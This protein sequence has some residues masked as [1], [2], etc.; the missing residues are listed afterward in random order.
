MHG[1]DLTGL[2]IQKILQKLVGKIRCRDL[3]VAHSSV[4]ASHGKGPAA[5]EGEGCGR[6]EILHGKAGTCQPVPVEV[7]AV[8]V[9]HV[10]HGVHELQAILAV[11]NLCHHAQTFEVVHQIGLNVIQTGLCLTHGLGF[12]AEGDIFGLGQA[13]IALRKLR[14]QHL[15]VLTADTVEV[16]VSEGNADVLFK[17]LCIRCHVHEGQFKVDRAVEKIQEGAPLFKD[18][19]LVLLLRQLV[20]D[21]LILNGLGVIPV[22]Y[23]ADAIRKHTLKGNRLLRGAGNAVIPLRPFDDLLHLPRL[24]FRQILRHVQISFFCLS[25]QTF[26]RKQ[27]FLPPFLPVPDGA[28]RHSNCLSDKGEPSALQ[29]WPE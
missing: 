25:E 6:D 3:Q 10:E 23:T 17:H 19:G 16:V 22:A 11:Q 7:K 14:L 21:V 9:A 29:T 28:G 13:V 8:I 24:R 18:R 27:C 2:H 26:H 1:D 4:E 15:A 20:V 12:N 5:G